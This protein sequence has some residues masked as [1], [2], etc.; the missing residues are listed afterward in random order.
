[1]NQFW[2]YIVSAAA[3]ELSRL[4]ALARSSARSAS[5][6]ARRFLFAF[7]SAWRAALQPHAR[8]KSSV[9]LLIDVGCGKICEQNT[10]GSGRIQNLA[11]T[12]LHQVR[13][14]ILIRSHLF[15]H[16]QVHWGACGRAS[17]LRPPLC[18]ARAQAHGAGARAP[19]VRR[20]L[21]LGRL[22][23]RDIC[24]RR[25]RRRRGLAR[26]GHGRRRT[27]REKEPTRRAFLCSSQPVLVVPC[28]MRARRLTAP[29]GEYPHSRRWPCRVVG[30][31]AATAMATPDEPA[32]FADTVRPLKARARGLRRCESH[33]SARVRR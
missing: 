19:A 13:G 9:T 2:S 15:A 28:F 10:H 16:T 6:S 30:E 1:M 22:R 21:G 20:R 3:T 26:L 14:K 12:Y 33:G 25:R 17:V 11:P 7:T 4:A 27:V 18:L 24:A 5:V 31:V 32:S 29:S 8:A 23:G